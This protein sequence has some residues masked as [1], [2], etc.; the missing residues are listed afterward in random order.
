M[1][2]DTKHPLYTKHIPDWVQMRDCYAGERQIKGRGPTYLLPTPGMLQRGM[3]SN[4]P[5]GIRYG[6]YRMRARVPDFLREAVEANLGVLHLQPPTFEL[7]PQMEYLIERAT[8]RGDSL[9]LLLQRINEEQLITGRCGLLVDI[10]SVADMPESVR[11]GSTEL[12]LMALYAAERIINWD[13]G[14]RSGVMED[15]EGQVS[16]G[17]EQALHMVVLDESD[18]IRQ[19]LFGWDFENRYR[20]LSLGDLASNEIEGTYQ[21]AIL[22]S[23]DLTYDSAEVI[24]PS[25]LGATMDRIPFVFVNTKDVVAEPDRPPLLNLGNLMLTTYRGEADYRQALYLQGQDT[26]LIT[27]SGLEEGAQILAGAGER[28][29]LPTGDA[30][31]IGVDSNGLPEM[32]EAL[33]NDYRRGEAASNMTEPTDRIAES[34]EALRVRMSARTA[35]LN[36]IARTGAF[37]LQEALRHIARWMSLDPESVVVIP[38]LDFVGDTMTGRDAAWLMDAK[39]RGLPV[40]QESIHTVISDQG[41]TKLTWEEEVAKMEEEAQQGIPGALPVGEPPVEGQ[42][43]S[44]VDDTVTDATLTTE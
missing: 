23:N 28:I 4:E 30:K 38:N 6:A 14:T 5:G 36:Q 42:N 10:S 40:A 11:R 44:A 13:E 34:G 43:G 29:V 35:S 41:L 32:R 8:V 31:F 9:D 22:H 24:E 20:V 1:S 19:N 27:G 18:E 17:F 39:N 15:E 33:Q 16:S 21:V 2:V 7:P 26:L 12:P 3:A 25:Y 37:G